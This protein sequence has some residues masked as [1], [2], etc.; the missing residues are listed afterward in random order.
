MKNPRESQ[1]VEGPGVEPM[2]TSAQSQRAR[3][4]SHK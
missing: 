4:L 3:F 2:H 1:R